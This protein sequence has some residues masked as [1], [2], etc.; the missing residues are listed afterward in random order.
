M[1]YSADVATAKQ[2]VYAYQEAPSQDD[3][4]Y[5]AQAIRSFLDTLDRDTGTAALIALFDLPGTEA[6][7]QIIDDVDSRLVERAPA[8]VPEL[9]RTAVLGD[10]PARTHALDVLDQIDARDL[11]DGLVLVLQ[12]NAGDE[13]KEIAARSLVALGPGAAPQVSKA[14]RVP[15]AAYWVNLA[16]RYGAEGADAESIVS[17]RPGLDERVD[18]ETMDA[19]AS[20]GLATDAAAA[21]SGNGAGRDSPAPDEAEESV[22]AAP[23]DADADLGLFDGEAGHDDAE[24]GYSDSA[25]DDAGADEVAAIGEFDDVESVAQDATSDTAPDDA[26]AGDV[27]DAAAQLEREF[28]AY[29]EHLDQASGADQAGGPD[30]A[31][32]QDDTSGTDET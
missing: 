16:R 13:L 7:Q 1:E 18:E 24:T 11:A 3:K 28:Q 2:L 15:D 20:A 26:A 22:D 5:A 25:P 27:D 30:Q 29:K 8:A 21:V 12:S 23:D 32:G 31:S 17:Q 14:L 19:A 10:E 6:T 4:E 9:L